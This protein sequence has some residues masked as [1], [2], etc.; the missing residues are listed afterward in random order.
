MKETVEIGKT[1]QSVPQVTCIFYPVFFL[2]EK[3]TLT[4]GNVVIATQ[5][6]VQWLSLHRLVIWWAYFQGANSCLQGVHLNAH[7]IQK[8]L[9][10]CF[11]LL[12]TFPTYSV[13]FDHMVPFDRFCNI[14]CTL[15]AREI[16]ESCIAMSPDGN[17][18]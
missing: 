4:W 16:F 5:Y 1:Y 9:L 6:T 3:S 2:L 7:Y 14:S 18:F 10:F 13:V 11:A 15:S 17:N 8:G 12:L